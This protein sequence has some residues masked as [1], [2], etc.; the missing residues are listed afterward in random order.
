[1][2]YT[3]FDAPIAKKYA[4]AF[5][6]VFGKNIEYTALE[7]IELAQKFLSTHR[8]TLFFLQLPQFNSITKNSMMEDLVSYFSLPQQFLKLFSVL[9]ADSRSFLIPA[10]LFFISHFYKEQNNMVAF[11]IMSSH[12][13]SE[14][15]REKINVFLSRLINKRIIGIYSVKKNLIA[16]VA[17]QSIDYKWEYSVRKQ[18]MCLRS[19]AK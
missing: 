7:K 15:Q 4:Q 10:V 9:V 2:N 1:M 16:G 17:V 8:R 5:I 3:H 13:L 12:H 6:H 14:E 11:S 19:L 18:L